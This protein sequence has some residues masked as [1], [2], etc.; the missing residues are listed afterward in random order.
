MQK[1]LLDTNFLLI[2]FQFNVDIF[3]EIDRIILGSYKI[4]VLDKTIDELNSIIDDKEQKV[5]DR[6]AAK[7]GL[8]LIKAKKVSIIKTKQ[9]AVD[10]LIAAQKDYIV[11]TQDLGLKKRIKG[12]KIVLR[13]K[14]KLILQ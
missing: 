11:A 1:I 4:Y 8:Q 7:L 2:P 5:R 12:K 6:Q 14:K 13:A 10:D 9:G 3:A